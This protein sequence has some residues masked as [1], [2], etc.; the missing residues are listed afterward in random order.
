MVSWGCDTG[1]E[2]W[3][4]SRDQLL[5]DGPGEARGV[6]CF[7]Q[8]PGPLCQAVEGRPACRARCDKARASLPLLHVSSRGPGHGRGRWGRA[9]CPPSLGA[10]G[11]LMWRR[12]SST[13]PFNLRGLC[14]TVSED[15]AV[16]SPSKPGANLGPTLSPSLLESGLRHH[17]R[18]GARAGGQRGGSPVYGEY[19]PLSP[20]PPRRGRSWSCRKSKSEPQPPERWEAPLFLQ[21]RLPGITSWEALS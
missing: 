11:K 8:A 7:V 16:S 12:P 9:C 17:A 1:E 4:Q 18:E 20:P 14:S 15:P 19:V 13:C 3:P 10:H 21:Q 5:R 2:S 6:Q